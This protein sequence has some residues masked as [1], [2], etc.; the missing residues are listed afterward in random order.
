M[1]EGSGRGLAPE[2]IHRP[3]LMNSARFGRGT[4]GTLAIDATFSEFGEYQQQFYCPR[5]RSAWYSGNRVFPADRHLGQGLYQLSSCT[6]TAAS[7]SSRSSAARQRLATPVRDRHPEAFALFVLGPRKRL[8][9]S[10]TE[11]TAGVFSLPMSEPQFIPARPDELPL[12]PGVPYP[13]KRTRT[14]WS[15][16][17]ADRIDVAPN[18]TRTASGR[19]W[20]PI[21]NYEQRALRSGPHRGGEARCAWLINRSIPPP[22]GRDSCSRWMPDLERGDQATVLDPSGAQVY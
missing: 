12:G 9:Y 15:A 7:A 19:V 18:R 11:N 13:S 21:T 1:P 14:A 20:G 5:S 6:R 22:S 3:L 10:E 2:L 8:K 17:Q 16:G 4:A